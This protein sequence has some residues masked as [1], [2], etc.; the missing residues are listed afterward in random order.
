LADSLI[1]SID[2]GSSFLKV[3][4]FDRAGRIVARASR[5][6][7][8][9][10]P[11]PGRAEQDPDA[12]IELL[13][14]AVN[15]LWDPG[16]TPRDV[17][18][19]GLSARGAL[20]VFLDRGGQVLAPCW[21]DGRARESAAILREIVGAD[22][23]YQTRRLAS[24][25]FHL[26]RTDPGTFDRLHRPLFAKDFLLYR[27]TGTVATDPSSGPPEGIWPA[28][29]WNAVEFPVE[30]L[31]PVRPHTEIGGTLTR[32]MGERLGLPAGL[33]VGVG[34]HDGA[35]A[36]TGVGAILSGQTCFTLGTQ[37]VARTISDVPPP[38]GRGVSPYHYLPG[39]W[40]CS[41][42]L[43]LAGGAPT[44]VG[45]LLAE[46]ADDPAAIAH[47]HAD[48]TRIARRA[49]PG[50]NGVTYLPF[51]GGTVS[52]EVRP[53]SR[54]AFLGMS[55]ETTRAD[56]YRAALEGVA[57]AFRSVVERQREVGLRVD[58]IRLS[59]G[60]ARNDL[61]ARIFAEVLD[62]PLTVVEPE[63][64]TRGAAMFL[65]VGLGWF[66]S[67]EEAATTWVRPVARYEPSADAE[68]Y[69]RIYRRFRRLGEAVY[70]AEHE[71][72]MGPR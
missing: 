55:A 58:D 9:R 20:A 21:V 72:V 6:Y 35:C 36:N 16:A 33:P 18:G 34:G 54:A 48:L 56:L 23:D 70:A 71:L 38:R 50:A 1:L 22:L 27:L 17:A 49:A 52:P 29:L 24:Q 26:R 64:G 68:A 5:A 53:E 8:T 65:A 4:A 43:V 67:P 31:A 13:V 61:W 41:G 10:R 30:R 28:R 32:A 19:V 60:G 37:G 11:A 14:D 46:T 7:E 45:R 59:G 2:L 40:C 57:C 25:V 63:E 39:R 62:A 66:S 3:A 42:D 12:W 15:S 44:L 69:E 47:L 51:P